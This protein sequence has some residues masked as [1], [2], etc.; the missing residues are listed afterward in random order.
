MKGLAIKLIEKMG[1]KDKAAVDASDEPMADYDVAAEEILAAVR[2]NDA[3]GLA[4][5]LRAF[6]DMC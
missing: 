1:P 4:E 2:Q 5:A 3:A 6:V